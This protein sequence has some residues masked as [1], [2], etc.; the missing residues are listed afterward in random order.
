VTQDVTVTITGTNDTPTIVGGSTTPTG[1]VTEDQTIASGQVVALDNADPNTDLATSGTIT[2]QDVDLI[3]THTASFVLK[4]T[5]ASADLP[6]FTEGSGAGAAN[7]GTFAI[8]ASVTEHNN[9]TTN[10]GTL[11][12]TFT[13]A[14]SDPVLQSLAAGETIT[15]GYTGTPASSYQSG[16]GRLSADRRGG[17]LPDRR[18][19]AASG[20]GEHRHGGRLRPRARA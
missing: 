13:L 18:H 7:I 17:R 9:D 6:G 14:D 11:G 15:Q 2:F 4:S 16:K 20:R 8:D 1:G 5:D 19:D 12:W 3:D 10:T